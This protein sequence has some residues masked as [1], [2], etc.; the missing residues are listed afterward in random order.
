[1]SLLSS[2]A[3]GAQT[4]GA[5]ATVTSNL[6]TAAQQAQKI[7]GEAAKHLTWESGRIVLVASNGTSFV[8]LIAGDAD[9]TGGVGGWQSSQRIFRKPAAW[10]QAPVPSAV[11]YPIMLDI[12]ELPAGGTLE[13]RLDTLYA[14]GNPSSTGDNPPSIRLLG[15]VP[16]ERRIIWKLDTVEQTSRLFSPGDFKSLRRVSITIALSELDRV[17]GIEPLSVRSTRDTASSPRTRTIIT[18]TGDTLRSIAVQ[19]LGQSS[20]F[21][22]IQ[23]W[24]PT[25]KKTDPDMPLR[26]GLKIVLK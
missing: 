17:S 26:P 1:M 8:A 12:D 18:K 3:Q 2:A 9:R 22:Q 7:G 20:D 21:T 4:I 6:S 13:S 14:M 10:F 16:T 5:S 11:T 19:Q 24:N 25:L 23:A 15:D